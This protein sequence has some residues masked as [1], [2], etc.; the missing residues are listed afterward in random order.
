MFSKKGV[1]RRTVGSLFIRTTAVVAVALVTSNA[2]VGIRQLT[3]DLLVSSSTLYV[4]QSG[5]D[6][7]NTTCA[8]TMP[9]L[10]I[11]Q[12]YSNAQAGDTII[13]GSSS[14]SSP[15][16]ATLTIDKDITIIVR[17]RN[18]SCIVYPAAATTLA[19]RI[20]VICNCVVG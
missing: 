19:S 2:G 6:T 13:L 4:S 20:S 14:A 10:T 11:G 16:M 7:N 5:S 18:R 1:I 15:F 17:S 9:C 8:Q 12:A 3:N